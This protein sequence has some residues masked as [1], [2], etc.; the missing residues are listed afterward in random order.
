[1]TSSKKRYPIIDHFRGFAILLMIIFHFAYDLNLFQFVDIDFQFNFFWFWLPR[2]IVFLFLFSMGLSLPIVHHPEFKPKIFLKRL[3]FISFWAI[4]ISITT[5]FLF[6][7]SWIY[8]GTLHCI[9][10]TSILSI[11][12][13][14][15]KNLSIICCLLIFLPFLIFDKTIPWILLSHASMD[16]IP[17][18]PWFSC[19]LLGIYCYHQ[20]IISLEKY[21]QFPILTHF[22]AFLSFLGKHP[23][24]IYILHQP[25][26]FGTV[27]LAYTL[28]HLN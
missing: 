28:T 10:L 17:P 19:V 6:P 1:M 9:A 20:N 11:P 15:R 13:I 4:V 22:F 25:I 5:Y 24:K 3:L 16:Y 26:L 21:D 7:N 14:S 2:L 18:F 8:F 27:K 12:F 23:L